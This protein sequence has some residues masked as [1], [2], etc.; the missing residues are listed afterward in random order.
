MVTVTCYYVQISLSP[1][2]VRFLQ[3][4]KTNKSTPTFLAFSSI[5]IESEQHFQPLRLRF[6]CKFPWFSVILPQK[7]PKRQKNELSSGR[8]KFV[9]IWRRERDSNP[10]GRMP[11]RFSRH[12]NRSENDGFCAKITDDKRSWKPSIYKGFRLFFVRTSKNPCVVK[13][14]DF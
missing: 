7:R 1:P 6:L 9:F 10:C 5:K 12:I 8:Q 3:Q 13:H 14:S 11:K 4:H 2:F